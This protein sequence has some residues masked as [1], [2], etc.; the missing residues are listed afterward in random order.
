MRLRGEVEK[1]KEGIRQSFQKVKDEMQYNAWH[2]EQSSAR[3]MQ[4]EAQFS[5]ITRQLSS[6][7]ATLKQASDNSTSTLAEFSELKKQVDAVNQAL[8]ELKQGDLGMMQ[9]VNSIKSGIQNVVIGLYQKLGNVESAVKDFERANE[10]KIAAAMT[11]INHKLEELE[12]RPQLD[13]ESVRAIIQ[14][15]LKDVRQEQPKKES[16][17][18]AQLMKKLDKNR[19]NLIK[20]KIKDIV[21]VRSTSLPELKEIIVDENEYCSKATFYRYIE[22]MKR[23][24]V[25]SVVE[26]DNVKTISLQE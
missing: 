11:Q 6:F 22:E 20:Q 24:K 14:E 8:D 16:R 15:A 17:L 10:Q 7:N 12:C 4:I 23:K 19:K 5:A 18:Q 1:L 3:V 2:M 13:K 26:I 9:E 25:L 21:S